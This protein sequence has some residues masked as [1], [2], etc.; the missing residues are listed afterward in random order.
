MYV[1][2]GV[3][4]AMALMA[5]LHQRF[6]LGE[7]DRDLGLNKAGRPRISLMGWAV[8]FLGSLLNYLFCSPGIITRIAAAVVE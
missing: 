6:V 7:L 1:G 8:F 4:A 2:G 3:N 5:I